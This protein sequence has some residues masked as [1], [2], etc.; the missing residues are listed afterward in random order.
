MT[1]A[2]PT[3]TDSNHY[4]TM[5][6]NDYVRVLEYTDLPGDSTSPHDHPNSVMI[7]LSGFRRLLAS[8]GATREVELPANQAVWLPAQS[9]SGENIGDTPTH[10]IIVELKGESAGT[11]AGATALGPSPDGH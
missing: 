2:D 8:G 4:R 6:E 10:T 5:W 9:H 3:V 7:T 1:G 11:P